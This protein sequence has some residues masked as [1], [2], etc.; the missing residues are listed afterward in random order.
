MINCNDFNFV[1]E[2]VRIKLIIQIE[3]VR[4]IL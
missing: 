3:Y 1:L 4:G 2:Q